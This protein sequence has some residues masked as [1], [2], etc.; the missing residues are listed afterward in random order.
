MKIYRTVEAVPSRLEGILQVLR[1]AGGK[2]YSRDTLLQLM[3]PAP[4]R[5]KEDAD[6][7]AKNSLEALF[8][9]STDG[10]NL[11]VEKSDERGQQ[12]VVLGDALAS[13]KDSQFSSLAR[14]ALR[15]AVVRANVDGRANQFAELLAWLKWI[16]ANDMPEGHA[17]LKM[18]LQGSKLDLE[19][20]GLNS[21]ARW[22]NVIYWARYVGLLWQWKDES[23][24]GM[25]ADTTEFMREHTSTLLGGGP[26][27]F[28][29]FRKRLGSLCPALDGGE[30]HA[31]ISDVLAE[32][33]AIPRDHGVRVSPAVSLGLRSLREAGVLDYGCPNDQREF[34]LMTGDEKVA[35]VTGVGARR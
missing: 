16:P 30:V 18:R 29:D 11:I 7:L 28:A 31:R 25:V 19:A 1:S 21:D 6:T 10:I 20:Y 8:E 15:T 26:V 3:Q 5:R 14:R 34:F 35:F 23:C 2:G 12:R 9:L 22:D 4:L 33:K 13:C 24:R 27:S 32:A 17:A